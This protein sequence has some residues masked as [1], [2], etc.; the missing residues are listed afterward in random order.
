[1]LADS[2]VL[3]RLLKEKLTIIVIT[4]INHISFRA[5]GPNLER[6]QLLFFMKKVGDVAYWPSR[7]TFLPENH[8]GVF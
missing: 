5:F 1:M 3:P 2:S 7:F 8:K 4:N 6:W